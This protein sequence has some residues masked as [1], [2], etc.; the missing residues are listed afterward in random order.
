MIGQP[1]ASFFGDCDLRFK[2]SLLPI[3]IKEV[4]YFT[5]SPKRMELA[6]E[7]EWEKTIEP[8]LFAECEDTSNDRRSVSSE[9]CC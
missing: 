2:P 9:A 7:I 5:A 1:M 8:P 4:Q 3:K 6:A